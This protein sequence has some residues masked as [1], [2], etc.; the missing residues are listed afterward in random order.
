MMRNRRIR[1]NRMGLRGLI[2]LALL[3]GGVMML[4]RR[5]RS[6]QKRSSSHYMGS[7]TAVHHNPMDYDAQ[8]KLQREVEILEEAD[9][10]MFDNFPQD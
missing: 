8:K 3:A 10:R 7:H 4:V 1:R 5:N 2:P 9:N 6:M